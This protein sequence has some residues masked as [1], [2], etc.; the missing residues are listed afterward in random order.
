ML[1]KLQFNEKNKSSFQ[2]DGSFQGFHGNQ[3]QF[4]WVAVKDITIT[5]L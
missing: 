5:N 2:G 1:R 4:S 3:V